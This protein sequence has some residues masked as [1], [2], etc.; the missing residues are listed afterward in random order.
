MMKLITLIGFMALSTLASGSASDESWPVGRY[1]IETSHE[2]TGDRRLSIMKDG[3]EVFTKTAGQFWFVAAGP[4]G[5]AKVAAEPSVSDVTGD[6]IPDLVLEQFP[7]NARCCWSYSIVSMGPAVKEITTV[8][9]FPSP[10]TV[11]DI[12]HDGVYE[13][14]GDDWA[15]YSWYA[16]PKIVLRYDK[17]QYRLAANLMEHAAPPAAT[18]AAKAAEFRKATVYAGFPVPLEVYRYMLELIYSGNAHSAWSFLNL[19]WPKGKSGKAEF[20]ETFKQQ[21]AKSRFWPEVAAMS[22]PPTSR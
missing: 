4:G 1:T 16:S 17:G 14:T 20:I 21:L 11:E 7:H 9:G 12:N 13:L 6:G 19:A 3:Q 15:F 5:I 18:L 22:A 2:S 8:G 10:M